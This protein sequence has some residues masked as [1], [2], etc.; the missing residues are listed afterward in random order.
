MPQFS[1]K[2]CE[3]AQENSASNV[4]WP[5]FEPDTSPNIGQK[6]CGLSKLASYDNIKK[7]KEKTFG[8][9]IKN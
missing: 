3:K 6:V 9:K 5:S 7:L 2:G 8:Q 4:Y 1:W